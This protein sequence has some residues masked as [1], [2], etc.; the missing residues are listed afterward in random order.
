MK[1]ILLALMALVACTTINAKIVKVTFED[2]TV[3]YYV[4]AQLSAIDFNDDGTATITSYDG[5]ELLKDANIKEVSISTKETVVAVKDIAMSAYSSILPSPNTG[6]PNT[7]SEPIGTRNVKQLNIFYPSVDPWGDP[8]TMSGVIWIPMNI[9]NKEDNSRGVILNSHLTITSPNSLPS[10]SYPTYESFILANPLNLDFIM[11]ESDFYGWGAT[12]RYPQAYCQGEP[13]GFAS[14][15]CLL[16]ARRILSEMNVNAGELN[17]NIGYSSAGFDAL[18]TQR[19]RD[20]YYR[21]VLSFDK[22]YAG[23]AP[24]DLKLCYIGMVE[25]NESSLPVAIPITWVSTKETQRLTLTYEE[26][27]VPKIAEMIPKYI[28]SKEYEPMTINMLLGTNKVK[29]M[30]NPVYCDMKSE[31]SKHIQEIFRGMSLNNNWEADPTQCIYLMHTRDDDCIP[32]ESGRALVDYLKKYGFT[33]SMISGA[34]NLQTN[35]ITSGSHMEGMVTWYTQM[36]ADIAAWPSKSEKAEMK[37]SNRLQAKND[38]I[39]IMRHFDFLGFDLRGVVNHILTAEPNLTE[40]GKNN[41]EVLEAKLNEACIQM[42][43]TLPDMYQMMKDSGVEFKTFFNDLVDYINAHPDQD[44]FKGD[45]RSLKSANGEISRIEEYEKQL[46]DWLETNGI[47][48]PFTK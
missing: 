45:I 21:D 18:S 2:N 29:E 12:E 40:N 19:V 11:V 8:I 10:M 1:K 33:P 13:N 31:E 15:D 14:V 38:P 4:S 47:K 22:T 23:G 44:I 48:T 37:T 34:T 27:F 24:S 7:D 32:T 3:K 42:G 28:Y 46:Y 9:W 41:T 43:T 6:K 16:A 39:A 36:I 26:A 35:F 25:M 30:L 5:N 20:K 17:F